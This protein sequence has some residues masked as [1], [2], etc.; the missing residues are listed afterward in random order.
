MISFKGK[1][2]RSE[3]WVVNLIVLPILI[4]LGV[5]LAGLTIGFVGQKELELAIASGVGAFVL[6]VI[7]TLVQI[8][9]A[10]RRLRDA[11]KDTMWVLGLFVPFTSL[12][13]WCVLGLLPSKEVEG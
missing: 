6:A 9:C 11:G 8:S 4:I 7:M 5:G 10:V 12:I 13:T 2:K 1:A 3:Y